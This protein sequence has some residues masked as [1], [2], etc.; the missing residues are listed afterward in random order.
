MELAKFTQRQ[1]GDYMAK[2]KKNQ[3]GSQR[4]D[5]HHFLYQRKHWQNGYAKLLREHPYCGRYIPQNSLHSLIHSKIHDIPTPSGKSCKRAYL[6][7]LELERSGQID[8]ARDSCEQRLDVL[9][10][11]WSKSDPATAEVLKLQREII[12]NFYKK[13]AR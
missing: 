10:K 9:I 4:E 5:F 6:K 3:H 8:I 11:V 7:I 1:G 2:N 13:A 12:A